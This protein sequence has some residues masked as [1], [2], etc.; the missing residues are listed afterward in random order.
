MNESAIFVLELQVCN[1]SI[2]QL[3]TANGPSE[4]CCT[5]MGR[6]ISKLSGFRSFRLE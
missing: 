6:Y 2:Y 5:K 4:A 1:D 3:I